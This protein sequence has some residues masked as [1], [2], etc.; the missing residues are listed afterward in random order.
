MTTFYVEKIYVILENRLNLSDAKYKKEVYVE[1]KNSLFRKWIIRSC[2]NN[3]SSWWIFWF[4]CHLIVSAANNIEPIWICGWP[5]CT[6]RFYINLSFQVLRKC[7]PLHCVNK[8]SIHSI[9][10]LIF[11]K[12]YVLQPT[13]HWYEILMHSL[14]IPGNKNRNRY[15]NLF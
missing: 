4:L 3:R 14:V 1:I 8:Y 7:C 13:I 12:I 2:Y 6:F 11:L 15:W 5:Y 9:Y 10:L